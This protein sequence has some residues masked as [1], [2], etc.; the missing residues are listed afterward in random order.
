MSEP[1]RILAVDDH[2]VVLE[3]ISAMIG[4]QADMVLIGTAVTGEQGIALFR[5]HRPDITLM[6]LQLPR[7]TGLETIRA[8]KCEAPAARVVVLTM[9]QGDEDIYRAL[10]AGAA[11][12]LLKD[13]LS[14]DLIEAIRKVYSG[15]QPL[16]HDVAASLAARESQP[17]LTPR[18]QE[19]IELIAAGL[20]NKEIARTL[21]ISDDTAKVHVRNILNKFNVDD[22]TAAVRIALQR[23]IIHL[24]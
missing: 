6:D 18:E 1:I 3:G 8:I 21:K 14:N 24:H 7:M 15:Q 5:E 11:A 4:R 19:V 12:Y 23:G 20:R 10:E 2:R 9:Y 17:L 13:A 16:P 22:R